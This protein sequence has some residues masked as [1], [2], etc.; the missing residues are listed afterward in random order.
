MEAGSNTLLYVTF[1]RVKLSLFL[2]ATVDVTS[3]PEDGNRDTF[4]TLD[5]TLESH[6][7]S[8]GKS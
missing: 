7:L 6:G 2:S 8:F 1:G 3:N 4:E 5:K